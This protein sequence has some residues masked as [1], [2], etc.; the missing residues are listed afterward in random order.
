MYI[1][2]QSEA[3]KLC[4]KY[5][6]NYRRMCS[7]HWESHGIPSISSVATAMNRSRMQHSMYRMESRS[8][9]GASWN[10]TQAPVPDARN[11]FW[12]VPSVPWEPIGM[13]A[14]LF[15]MEPARSPSPIVPSMSVM[16]RPTASRTIMIAK[17]EKP[18]IDSAIVAMNAKWHRDC[19][20]CQRCENPITTQ[21]FTIEGDKPVCSSCTC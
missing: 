17:C 11:P 1:H 18:I 7:T 2:T 21:T 13:I 20:R 4:N 14:V 9:A 19:F 5:V 10:D 3:R 12:S 6:Y 16:A 15:V 8:A